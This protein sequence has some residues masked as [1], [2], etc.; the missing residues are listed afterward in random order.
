M[1]NQSSFS[2][3]SS[4][5]TWPSHSSLSADELRMDNRTTLEVHQLFFDYLNNVAG[6]RKGLLKGHWLGGIN[7]GDESAIRESIDA[8]LSQNKS[9]AVR[10]LSLY[11]K[12]LREHLPTETCCFAHTDRIRKQI[13]L[14]LTSG[15]LWGELRTFDLDRGGVNVIGDQN[16]VNVSGN[17]NSVNV[18]GHHNQVTV[19]GHRN[20]AVRTSPNAAVPSR[21]RANPDNAD[22]LVLRE[23]GV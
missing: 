7:S 21:E 17:H 5:V 20:Q 2:Y 16:H 13:A 1:I 18:M 10:T 19:N 6:L 23:N 8:A 11:A 4:N 14:R 22:V 9:E 3:H 15:D 12:G